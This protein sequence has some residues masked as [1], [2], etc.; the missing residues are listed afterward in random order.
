MRGDAPRWGEVATL[1]WG[2]DQELEALARGLLLLEGGS[3]A[4]RHGPGR[5]GNMSRKH[6]IRPVLGALLALALT[7][8]G[9]LEPVDGHAPPLAAAAIP[10]GS[11][12]SGSLRPVSNEELTPELQRRA[13]DILEENAG[14]AVGATISFR[15]GGQRYVARIEEHYNPEHGDREP[16]GWHKG[17]TLYTREAERPGPSAKR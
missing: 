9:N 17:V 5:S 7:G 12:S 13:R 2:H 3:G 14:A 16:K 15:A 11:S 8:C 6:S 10:R 4:E 1:D